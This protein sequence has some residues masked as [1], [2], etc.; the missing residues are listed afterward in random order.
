[1]RWVRY[2][3][4]RYPQVSC[5]DVLRH[6]CTGHLSLLWFHLMGSPFPPPGPLRRVPRLHQYY[7]GLRLLTPRLGTLHLFRARLLAPTEIRSLAALSDRTARAWLRKPLNHRNRQEVVRSPEFPGY[8]CTR[9]TFSDPGGVVD[10]DRLVHT[11]CLP[12]DSQR[13]PPRPRR[14]R[15]SIARPTCFLCTLHV[16]GRPRRATLGSGWGRPAGRDLHPQGN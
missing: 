2:R 7:E 5:G 4:C 3:S 15:G 1:M 8:P 10:T 13:R 12:L 9:A 11:C 16:F 6:R 14:F